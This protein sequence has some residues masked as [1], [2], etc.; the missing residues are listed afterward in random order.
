LNNLGISDGDNVFH[1]EYED[2]EDEFNDNFEIMIDRLARCKPYT[3]LKLN[4]AT[5]IM[6]IQIPSDTD[7]VEIRALTMCA[8]K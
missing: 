3:L 8:F 4:E 6:E 1:E 7:D 2:E 5:K